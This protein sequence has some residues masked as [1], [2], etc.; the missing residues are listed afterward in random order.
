MELE[1]G[2]LVP[3]VGVDVEAEVEVLPLEPEAPHCGVATVPS[4]HRLVYH[5]WICCASLSE[6]E[7]L[8]RP[9][10]EEYRVVKAGEE[11]KH[12]WYAF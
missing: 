1:D 7:P 4:V 3:L 9:A 12:A 2:E 6:Q 11:Q 8:Q 5:D 10:D